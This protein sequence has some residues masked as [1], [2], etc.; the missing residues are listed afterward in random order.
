MTSSVQATQGS[1]RPTS[2][3]IRSSA[4]APVPTRKPDRAWTRGPSG[5][6]FHSVGASTSAVRDPALGVHGDQMV[7]P[8]ARRF[9]G[10]EAG[11]VRQRAMGNPGSGSLFGAIVQQRGGLQD[12]R[13]P[14]D[15]PVA[16]R[17]RAEIAAGKR[18][19]LR[20][21]QR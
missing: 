18:P 19:G 16:R 10:G 20:P 12:F 17:R 11:A 4:A 2:H 1:N 7:Q 13:E 21:A 14:G 15:Q 5:W 8:P 6:K 9:H 3:R